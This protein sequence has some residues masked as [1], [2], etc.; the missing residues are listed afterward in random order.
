MTLYRQYIFSPGQIIQSTQVNAEFDQLISAFNSHAYDADFGSN[1]FISNGDII[2]AITNLDAKLAGGGFLGYNYSKNNILKPGS[3]EY[4][5]RI[6]ASPANMSIFTKNSSVFL[7]DAYKSLDVST[8]GNNQFI[9]IYIEED[10]GDSSVVS[11]TKPIKLIGKAA[12]STAYSTSPSTGQYL[13]GCAYIKDSKIIG[14][15]SLESPQT[16]NYHYAVWGSSDPYSFTLTTTLAY[17]S[18]AI[19]V[20]VFIPSSISYRVETQVTTSGDGLAWNYDIYMKRDSSVTHY[21]RERVPPLSPAT[22]SGRTTRVMVDMETNTPSGLY[23]YVFGGKLNT[24]ETSRCSI[25]L[26]WVYG[27]FVVH[28]NFTAFNA[29]F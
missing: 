19:Y 18:K 28:P 16:F 29:R 13:V 11:G 10:T 15:H 23:T 6:E 12:G 5:V 25:T 2:T 27:H 7:E 21:I 8:V 3:N 4:S 20:P 22:N 1:N 24:D 9:D 14:I 26:N 17:S